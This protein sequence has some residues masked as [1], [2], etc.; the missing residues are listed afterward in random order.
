MGVSPLA[1][2]RHW[3]DPY[4]TI[5]SLI[6]IPSEKFTNLKIMYFVSIEVSS[7]VLSFFYIRIDN[8]YQWF[9]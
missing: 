4:N 2:P 5:K 8:L 7:L 3:S 1:R 6:L 9:N